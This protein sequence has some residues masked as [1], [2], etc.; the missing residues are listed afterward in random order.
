MSVHDAKIYPRNGLPYL[1]G[2]CDGDKLG[3]KTKKKQLEVKEARK[4]GYWCSIR[5]GF[6]TS[7]ADRASELFC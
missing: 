1:E 6:H 5:Q 2:H 4:A 3:T 7:G